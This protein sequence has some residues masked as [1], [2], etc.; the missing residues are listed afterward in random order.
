[1]HMNGFQGSVCRMLRTTHSRVLSGHG[2]VAPTHCLP[3]RARTRRPA[4]IHT[5]LSTRSTVLYRCS[6]LRL[7]LC[8]M[9]RRR[10]LR[11]SRPSC[12]TAK[13]RRASTEIA[14]QSPASLPFNQTIGAHGRTCP[15]RRTHQM[16]DYPTRPAT[17]RGLRCLAGVRKARGVAGYLRNNVTRSTSGQCQCTEYGVLGSGTFR[18]AEEGV[19]VSRCGTAVPC[20]WG[21]ASRQPFTWHASNH[22]SHA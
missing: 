10:P 22:D 6:G 5:P 19:C 4:S 3:C 7:H 14:S 16:L 12:S 2:A 1:L 18:I 17:A 20:R 9:P 13:R 11:A 21:R 8:V 15:Y